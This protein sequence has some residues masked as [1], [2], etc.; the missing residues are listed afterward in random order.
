MK[1]TLRNKH[2]DL[3]VQNSNWSKDRVK[4]V[5]Q[6]YIYNDASTLKKFIVYFILALGVGFT[7]A[8][9]IFFFAYNWQDM[10]KFF[11]LGLVSVVLIATVSVTLF[12]H[13]ST[14]TRHVLITIA[15]VLVGVLFA[16]F[17][18]IYQTGANAYDFFLGWTLFIL[19]WTIVSHFSVLWLIF[20]VLVNT[21]LF[22]FEEQVARDWSEILFYTILYL[23]NG[24]FL[25]AF[26]I[27]G[28]K[29]ERLK[30]PGWFI[31][32][33]ALI[34]VTYATL[35]LTVGMFDEVSTGYWL[36]FLLAAIAYSLAVIKGL[37]DRSLFYLALVAFSGIT[38]VSTWILKEGKSEI[39]FFM[40]ALFVILSVTLVVSLFVNL[41]KKWNNE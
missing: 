13:V 35:G 36:L 4:G 7:L 17:G 29:V 34:T 22:L 11:K 16:V 10:H 15:S 40:V 2:I 30:L 31:N 18:Q 20:I 19:I 37:R 3:I 27:L 28:H 12:I 25:L 21:T 8:G 32:T 5:L 14:F 1:N 6:E 41:Q 39:V 38:I 9:I 23:V 24:F 33:L 26:E